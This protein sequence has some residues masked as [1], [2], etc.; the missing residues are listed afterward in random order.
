VAVIGG[1][2]VGAVLLMRSVRVGAGRRAE[3]GE[4]VV[5]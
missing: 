4:E 1:L 5:G 3:L 2:V